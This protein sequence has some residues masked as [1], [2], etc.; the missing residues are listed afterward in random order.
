[1]RY[2]LEHQFES[3]RGKED[4]VS[5]V[6]QLRERIVAVEDRIDQLAID[7]ATTRAMA[8]MADRDVAVF[9]PVM[10]GTRGC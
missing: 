3:H 2:G 1:M 9:G 7:A 6:G 8:A 5:D 10:R 4:T